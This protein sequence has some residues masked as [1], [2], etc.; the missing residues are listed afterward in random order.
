MV[1]YNAI[2]YL[3]WNLMNKFK[4]ERNGSQIGLK[5]DAT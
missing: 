3:Y 4:T 1:I 2:G 5:E